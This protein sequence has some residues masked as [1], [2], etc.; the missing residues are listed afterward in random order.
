MDLQKG[1]VHIYTGEGKGKTTAAMGM[2]LR[3]A[4]AGLS[5]VVLHFMKTKFS[6]EDLVLKKI[7]N[8][9][10]LKFGTPGWVKGAG[11]LRDKAEALRGLRTLERILRRGQQAC[12][13]ADEVCVAVSLGLISEEALFACL[14][15]RPAQVE[16]VLTGR[17]AT[18]ALKRRADLVTNMKAE[19]HYFSRGVK[20]RRGIEY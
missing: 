10:V 19:K 11:R 6:S 1:Y 20:A 8:V 3:A 15:V 5:V 17:G 14:A 13:I 16:L 12:V 2:A 7:K 9:R 4:G 18:P